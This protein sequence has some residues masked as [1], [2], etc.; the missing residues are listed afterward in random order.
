MQRVFRPTR[1]YWFNEVVSPALFFAG[2]A[3]FF[4]WINGK[5]GATLAIFFGL[6]A[7]LFLPNALQTA[8]TRLEIDESGM[9]GLYRKRPFDYPWSEVRALRRVRAAGKKWY[10][11]I[12]VDAGAFEFPLE[13]FD[14]E[15]VWQWLQTTAP[16]RVLADD[17]FE[18]LS[19][20]K[21]QREAE[22]ALLAGAS[23][24]VRVR[25]TPWIAGLGW[26]AAAFL[27]FMIFLALRSGDWALALLLCLAC[28]VVA[29]YLI[30]AGSAI[31]EIERE[32]IRV[33]MPV[34]VTY[35]INWDEVER[36]E[37]DHGLNQFVLYGKGKR[38]TVPGPAFWRAADKR[39]AIHAMFAHMD[40]RGIPFDYRNRAYFALPKGV[41]V[42]RH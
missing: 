20:V 12:G 34:W 10:L 8:R 35:G 9:H 7:L 31:V 28:V 39:N 25:I 3:L 22:A 1:R 24:P 26:V 11:Q 4:L 17:A 27:A 36:V 19:W 42:R 32:A 40:S 14:A 18:Q 30:W 5:T 15:A 6:I 2:L 21:S 13:Q 37:I 33:V 23:G 41:R 16:P 29:G 38:M